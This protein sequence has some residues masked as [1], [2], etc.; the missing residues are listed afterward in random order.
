MKSVFIGVF[1]GL[2][3]SQVTHDLMPN[4]AAIAAEGVFFERHHPVFPSVTRI[5]AASMVTGRYPGQHG[6]AAN[7]FVVRDFHPHKAMPALEPELDE[8][9]RKTGKV[10][11]CP[12]LADILSAHGQEYIAIGV[13]TNGNAYVHNPTA[14][15]S[16]G[17]TIHPD[18]ALPRALYDE[19]IR[20]FGPWPDVA[21]PNTPRMAHAAKIM[22]EYILAE[23]R[24]IVSLIWSSEPDKSQHVSGV[25]SE[26][27]RRAITEADA[28]FGTILTWLNETGRRDETDIFI[29]SD[30]GYSTI[31]DVI[32]IEALV[33]AAG[34][35]PGDQSGGVTVAGNG[36][37]VLFYVH[38]KDHDTTDRLARWLMGQP[39]CGAIMASSAVHGIEGTLP[40]DLV[41]SEGARAPE[42]TMSFRWDSEPNGS[43]FPGHAY[44]ASGSAGLGQHG[45]LSKHEMNNTL[46]ASGPSFKT[47]VRS[48]V[49][50][51]NVDLAPT[52]LHLLGIAHENA[53]NGRV[54]SEA[55]VDGPD[56]G[57]V[58]WKQ[59]DHDARRKVGDKVYS[60]RIEVSRVGATTY[61]DQGNA[62]LS[63]A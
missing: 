51:G 35:P 20:T 28:Q 43:G 38:D 9:A 26:L 15:T 32:D 1:D 48:S 19:V 59:D 12:T 53:F 8:L 40:A 10:L 29:V 62:T 7:T 13:G 2:Q 5:N 18:F 49:P 30:H 61:V 25:G 42:L 4:V 33:S 6:L 41:G 63:D 16:G 54:L 23:R 36:G 60:Q 22:R 21:S 56:P 58:Q 27:A 31:S 57:S 44:S 46:I 39:W 24:P 3:P 34:F 37:C 50:S 11:L 47:G 55:L 45:S 52:I 14:E 17:A